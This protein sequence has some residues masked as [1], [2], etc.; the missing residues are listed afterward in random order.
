MPPNIV[1]SS[2]IITADVASVVPKKVKNEE[3]RVFSWEEVYYFVSSNQIKCIHRNE[4]VQAIYNQWMKDTLEKYG[5]I[6]SYLLSTKLKEFVNTT[7]TTEVVIDPYRPKVIILPNDFPYSVDKGIQHILLWS[8][9][10]LARNYI[11]ETLESNYGRKSYEWV[12]FVNP[13]E[14]QSVRKLP[15]V[16]VFC[17]LDIQSDHR[18][19]NKMYYLIKHRKGEIC[20]LSSS[21]T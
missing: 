21:V 17:V 4:Q 12:Y 6:E 1:A 3:K 10:P 18:K 14:I 13:S 19:K 8:Q 16:H 7:T 15:H 11:E 2:S 5:S 20:F 9:T